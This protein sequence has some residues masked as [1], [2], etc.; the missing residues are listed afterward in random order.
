MERRQAMAWAGSIVLFGCVSALLLGSLGG[1]FGFDITQTPQPQAIGPAPQPPPSEEPPAP[2][3][4]Q[5]PPVAGSPVPET[6]PGDPES[7][8][9]SAGTPPALG[10]APGVE[11]YPQAPAD[12]G[13]LPVAFRLPQPIPPPSATVRSRPVRVLPRD[14]GKPDAPAEKEAPAQ[15]PGKARQRDIPIVDAPKRVMKNA[16]P[17]DIERILRSKIR[18]HMSPGADNVPDRMKGAG[19]KARVKDGKARGQGD[20]HDG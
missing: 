2:H 1:G 7:A 9:A 3:S 14:A 20:S 6:V 18:T 5:A 15:I 8:A 10:A 13:E 17:Q 16:R 11:H 4:A 19:P 12:H